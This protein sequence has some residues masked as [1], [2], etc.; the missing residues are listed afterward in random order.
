[1]SQCE[2]ALVPIGYQSVKHFYIAGVNFYPPGCI[3]VAL[4]LTRGALLETLEQEPS[5]WLTD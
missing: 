1:M 3:K 4:E 5:E 2:R